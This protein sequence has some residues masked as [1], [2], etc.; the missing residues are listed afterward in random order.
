M[1]FLFENLLVSFFYISQYGLLCLLYWEFDTHQFKHKSVTS[2]E[3]V[4]P[5]VILHVPTKKKLNDLYHQKDCRVRL[6]KVIQ[7]H[8]RENIEKTLYSGE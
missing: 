1:N 2:F 5:Q 6:A 7:L 3:R 8:V 4:S